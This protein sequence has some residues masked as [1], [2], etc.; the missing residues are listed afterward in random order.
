MLQLTIK[1]M[2]VFSY[3]LQHLLFLIIKIIIIVVTPISVPNV[4]YVNTTHSNH[5]PH[6]YL[7]IFSIYG[8]RASIKPKNKE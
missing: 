4:P 8:Y 7:I 2:N 5:H 1:C 6:Y 3:S